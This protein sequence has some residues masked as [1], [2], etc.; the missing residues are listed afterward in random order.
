MV[1][2]KKAPGSD[3]KTDD[4]QYFHYVKPW[5]VPFIEKM[6]AVNDK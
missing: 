3:S 6:H 2:V 4:E 1:K 5:V